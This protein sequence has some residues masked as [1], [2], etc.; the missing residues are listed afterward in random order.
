MIAV[1]ARLGYRKAIPQ[2][3][4]YA[5]HDDPLVRIFTTRALAELGRKP[6]TDVLLESLDSKDPVIRREAC[7]AL[8]SCGGPQ[9]AVRLNEMARMDR[10]ESVRDEAKIGLFRM[11]AE[12]M[13]ELERSEL[14]TSLLGRP[15]K[16]VR[17]WA[18]RSLAYQCG[19][20]GRDR[21]R[22]ALKAEQREKARIAFHLLVQ[23]DA[24]VNFRG[25]F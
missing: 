21:L 19:Q 3:R 16:K 13:N 10:I 25:G 14:L 5:D 2:I 4:R 24:D 20:P 17:A 22:K 8:A 12:R 15:E 1:L 7:A 6:A 9:A 23:Q 11:Q 18:V